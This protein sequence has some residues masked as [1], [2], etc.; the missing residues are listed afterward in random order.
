M[1]HR[2]GRR[3]PNLI[4]STIPWA[5]KANRSHEAAGAP[6]E[7]STGKPPRLRAWIRTRLPR[8]TV[9]GAA[10]PEDACAPG[11]SFPGIPNSAAIPTKAGALMQPFVTLATVVTM[12]VVG[13]PPTLVDDRWCSRRKG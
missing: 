12:R 13:R 6:I 10:G 4:E 3:Q 11:F 7:P 5:Y 1:A 8:M 2:Y 9:N